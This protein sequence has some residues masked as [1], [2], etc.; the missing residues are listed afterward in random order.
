MH[1]S[2]IDGVGAMRLAMAFLATRP[3]GRGRGPLPPVPD[4]EDPAPAALVAEALADRGRRAASAVGH[5]PG[6]VVR[7]ARP[8]LGSA[9]GV[10]ALATSTGRMLRPVTR[11]LSPIMTGRS[12]SVRFDTLE[13]RLPE[14][15]AAAQAVDGRLND[16]FLAAVAGGFRRYH[17]HHRAPVAELRTTM[18][19]NIRPDEDEVVAGNQFMPARLAFPGGI[20][21][22]AARMRA[23]RD[24]VRRQRAEPSLGVVEQVSAILNRL[25]FG[26]ATNV[27]GSMLKAIGVVTSNVPGAP[28]PIY[29]AGVRLEANFGFGPLGGAASNITMLSYLD[30]VHV[31]VGT[32]PAA[33]PDPDTF[34]GFLQEGFDEVA[35]VGAGAAVRPRR[36]AR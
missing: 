23:I 13:E 35:S 6:D 11:P 9:R 29:L 7:A 2:V 25:R 1:H 5:V 21:D 10:A 15:Q 30:D 24:L 33:V 31:A 3:E 22:P 32:D 28:V 16:A 18:P 26:L 4:P 36:R 27:L 19:I 20:E 17:V 34:L 8:P 12:L 14:L